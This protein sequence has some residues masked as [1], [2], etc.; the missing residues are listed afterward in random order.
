MASEGLPPHLARSLPTRS[1]HDQSRRIRPAGRAR[2]CQPPRCPR[3]AAPGPA[4][5]TCRPGAPRR[6]A[7]R[8][9][10]PFTP[11]TRAR[12]RETESAEPVSLQF[13]LKSVIGSPDHQ[14]RIPF[15]WCVF[16]SSAKGVRKRGKLLG[17]FAAPCSTTISALAGASIRERLFV[18]D[19]L[20]HG[21]RRQAHEMKARM[22]V[23]HTTLAPNV[24]SSKQTARAFRIYA[25]FSPT[26]CVAAHFDGDGNQLTAS[27]RPTPSSP[28]AQG[29]SRGCCL[30]VPVLLDNAR[31]E[32][33][34]S[35]RK[36]P[37]RHLLR[38]GGGQ[39]LPSD[40]R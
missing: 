13:L 17:A 20:L 21:F 9:P 24:W 36:R 35:R 37:A 29:G 30:C 18:C 5:T 3:G 11:A 28:P 40:A 26:T 33:P 6:S 10:P 16:S 22:L 38:F 8:R 7:A 39:N 25:F 4:S 14:S 19:A 32:Q 1:A 34:A 15:G 12:V 23:P 31:V 27:P 2:A